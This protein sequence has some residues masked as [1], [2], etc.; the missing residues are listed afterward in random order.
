MLHAALLGLWLS[1]GPVAAT[2]N[3][4]EVNYLLGRVAAS[5]CTFVRN[6]KAHDGEAAAK[7]LRRKYDYGTRK[8]GD[9]SAEQ[10]IEHV[11]TK[12]SWTGK[13]Y[14]VDCPDGGEERSAAWLERA[15]Q[16]YRQAPA[17]PEA[18]R[19]APEP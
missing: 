5:D 1:A 2:P 17:A 8:H 18:A 13:Y 4:D 11:A 15:L 14:T 12:S 9:I 19:T 7:H 16:Q 10:F 6:G 3:A